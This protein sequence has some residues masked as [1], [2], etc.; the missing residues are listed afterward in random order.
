M[1][2]LIARSVLQE[3]MLA[4]L[5]GAFGGLALRLAALGV[6][7]VMAYQVARRRREIGIHLALGAE[8]RQVLGMVVGQTARLVLAG[9]ALG[10]PCALAL[11]R[12]ASGALYGLGPRDPATFAAAVLALLLVAVVAACVPGRSATRI[13]PIESLRCD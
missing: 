12:F 1:D 9:S 2:D 11:T 3:R 5:A 7:G 13:D 8:P 4:T 10:V 6:Y